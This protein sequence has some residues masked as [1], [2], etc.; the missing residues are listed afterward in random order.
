MRI[1]WAIALA[2]FCFASVGCDV[3]RQPAQQGEWSDVH[4]DKD[5]I[6]QDAKAPS[7]KPAEK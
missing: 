7:E 5:K 1:W 6:S 4:S 3:I 2:I